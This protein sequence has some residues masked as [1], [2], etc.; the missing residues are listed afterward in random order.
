[1]KVHALTN[2]CKD[3][4]N[5]QGRSQPLMITRAFDCH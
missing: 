5:T 1:M 3:F 4:I 2:V